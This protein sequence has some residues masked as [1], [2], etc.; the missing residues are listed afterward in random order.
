EKELAEV[1]PAKRASAFTQALMDLGATVCLPNGEPQCY[2]C[3]WNDFCKG[4]DHAS[5]LPVRKAKKGRKK[6]EHTVFLLR[7]GDEV[8]LRKRP[9]KGLLA[10]MWEFPNENGFWGE[11]EVLRRFQG[12]LRDLG[13][14]VHVFSHVEWHMRGYEITLTDKVEDTEFVWIKKEEIADFA[15]PSA[16]S[17]FKKEL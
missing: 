9:S 7:Y 8:A 1:I 4:K 6:E 5:E 2:R 17:Y 11:K 13:S 14:A 15:I 10:K 3:P 12:D 16:F